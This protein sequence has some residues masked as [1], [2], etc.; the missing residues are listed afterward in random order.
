[1]YIYSS[2]SANAWTVEFMNKLYVDDDWAKVA[3]TPL[4]NDHV[5]LGLLVAPV[6]REQK[7]LILRVSTRQMLFKNN[8]PELESGIN[9]HKRLPRS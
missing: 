8:D 9:P 2:I 4:C 6:G 5:E 7:H 3:L 1:M